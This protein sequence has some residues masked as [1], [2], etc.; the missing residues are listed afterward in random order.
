M[1]PALRQRLE[2]CFAD[3][4]AGIVAVYV[5][6]SVARGE[7]AAASDVDVAVL[8]DA[9]PAATLTGPALT[10][11]G[12]IERALGRRVDL[13]ALNSAPA[14][15]VHRVLRDGIIVVDRDPSAR[16]RFEVR[17]RNEYFDLEPIRRRYRQG[18]AER[19]VPPPPTAP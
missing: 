12:R 1:D 11:E 18:A 13:V 5:F 19:R 10:L 2:A 4:S 7:D 8:F 3:D 15:L 17:R 16:I 6:G 9:P 14:D